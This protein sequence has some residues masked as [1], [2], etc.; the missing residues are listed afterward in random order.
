MSPDRR[1]GMVFLGLTLMLVGA[2]VVWNY[3]VLWALGVALILLS[4]APMTWA[5]G[6]STRATRERLIIHDR[7]SG[8]SFDRSWDEITEI[9]NANGAWVLR[10]KDDELPLPRSMMTAIVHRLP[11][12]SVRGG[13][14]P[15]AIGQLPTPILVNR[16]LDFSRLTPAL[17]T[18]G[19]GLVTLGLMQILARRPG[20]LF[21]PSEALFAGTLG[22]AWAIFGWFIPIV[23]RCRFTIQVDPD[24]VQ[25]YRG[26]TF[27]RIPWD[28]AKLVEQW[29]EGILSTRT[30]LT[31][32]GEGEHIVIEGEMS[33]YRQSLAAIA[34]YAREETPFVGFAES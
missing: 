4:I 11:K 22:A 2:A 5:L 8:Q 34:L 12:G 32:Y 24:G 1:I 30:T 31:I 20:A 25:L 26:G 7:F 17:M 13:V 9:E 33:G 14:R 6:S 29:H 21:T 3:P 18:L 23:R 15:K 16:G 19:L 27:V 28:Q 10:S